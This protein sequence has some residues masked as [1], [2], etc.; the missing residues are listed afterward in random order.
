MIVHVSTLKDF[1]H[2]FLLG[3]SFC[4]VSPSCLFTSTCAVCYLHHIE[5][6]FLVS[7]GWPTN[8]FVNTLEI[9]KNGTEASL[10]EAVYCRRGSHCLCFGIDGINWNWDI[11][12]RLP[13]I[14]TANVLALCYQTYRS[15]LSHSHTQFQNIWPQED[16]RK[17]HLI[18]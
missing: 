10:S 17:T 4:F 8:I 12:I 15:Q 14:R 18:R 7:I 1:Y 6:T 2:R 13:H 3:F 11:S 16:M 9:K 5:T